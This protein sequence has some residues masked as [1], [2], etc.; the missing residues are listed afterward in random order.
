MAQVKL[1]NY[2]EASAEVRT[3][4]DDIMKTRNTDYIKALIAASSAENSPT[5]SPV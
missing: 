3:V 1:V 2:D 4:F 5:R